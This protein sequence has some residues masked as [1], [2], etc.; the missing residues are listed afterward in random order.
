MHR[1]D[2]DFAHRDP[3]VE[4]RPLDAAGQ[5][6]A[7]ALRA[8]FTILK[9]IMMVLVVLYLFSNVRCVQP[10]EQALVLRLGHLLPNVENPGLV[11]AFPYPIDEIVPL[12]TNKV[13]ETLID[14]HTFHRSAGEVG[15]S[16]EM[17][18]RDERQGLNP[19]LDGALLTADG[20]LVHARWS[21]TYKIDRV[22]DFV[23]NFF[24]DKTENAEALIRVLV[25]TFGIRVATEMTAEEFI[26]TRANDVKSEMKW[27]INERLRELNAGIEVTLVEMY[28]QTPPLQIRGAFER[29]QRNENFKKKRIN[30]A[31]KEATQIL[32]RAAGSVYPELL[33]LIDQIDNAEATDQPTDELRKKLDRLLSDRVE[34]EANRLISEA[35]AYHAVVVGRMQSDVELY[36]SLLPE[37]ER[38]PDL[39]IA[40]LWER[41]QQ[42]I[43]DNPGVRKL[44][45]PAG[46]KIRI[47]IPLDPESERI[48]EEERLQDKK[49]DMRDLI[50]PRRAAIVPDPWGQ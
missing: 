14:S 16:L 20:G 46:T 29:T 38:N 41:T 11:W 28:E 50:P 15:Q 19:S 35:S 24:G 26:R 44:Y 34:G 36:R 12:P 22:Q 6:L 47:Q 13:N 10:H 30:E 49:F 32:S 43:F 1:N 37:Y 2:D 31:K 18:S 25:E 7:D 9:G 42:Y 45:K 48:E 39:L 40:R 33:D 4:E 23:T 3:T 8:S 5:S 21:I 27:R 17:I